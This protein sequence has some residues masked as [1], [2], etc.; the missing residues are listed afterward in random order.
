L[1]HEVLAGQQACSLQL[2]DGGAPTWNGGSPRSRQ[3]GQD[4]PIPVLLIV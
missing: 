1:E 3:K 4:L 2:T